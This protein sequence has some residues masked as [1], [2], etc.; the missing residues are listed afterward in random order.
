MDAASHPPQLGVWLYPDAPVASLVE[1]IERAD[2][3]DLDEVWLAD[4]GPAREPFVVLAAAART[5]TRIR[6]GVGITSPVLRHPGALAASAATLDELSGGRAM[7]GLGLGGTE[8]LGPFGLAV[9]RPVARMRDAIGVAR[10]VLE[11]RPVDGYEPPRHAA[12][13]RAVPIFVGA[14][15]EQLNRLAS[16]L[17]DGVFLSGFVLGDHDEPIAW[18]RSVRPIVV[19]LYASVRFAPDAPDDPSALA[20]DPD[21]VA[22]GLVALAR[23]YRPERLGLALVDGLDPRQ[24]IE[25]ACAALNL[26]RDRLR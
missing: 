8:S 4:E 12:P 3:A 22:D 17:A 16:R 1:A 24:M 7:L 18:A 21:T 13:A 11:R 23:R 15:G 6:L 14:R 26:A 25:P 2:R 20:G 5:T 10:A 9:E 19:A